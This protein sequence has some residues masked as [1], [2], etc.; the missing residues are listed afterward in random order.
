MAGLKE[1]DLDFLLD[2]KE[3]LKIFLMKCFVS[4]DDFLDFMNK[5]RENLEDEASILNKEEFDLICEE[6]KTLLDEYHR[7]F[8]IYNRYENLKTKMCNELLLSGR[9]KEYDVIRHS[10][11]TSRL[12][13]DKKDIC[14]NN[15]SPTLDT[16]CDCLGVVQNY[17][18]RKLTPKECF[19][20][21]GVKDEDFENIAQNQSN[22]SLY[23]LAG[24]SIVVDVLMAIFKEMLN[25]SKNL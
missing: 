23:H 22:A 2:N 17:R 11:S 14:Q 4:L 10:Y 15:I 20:L 1:K 18:I 5:S 6:I 9:C 13:G 16:R 7:L 8:T 21:M 25:F 3:F 12:N 19:R 24:D